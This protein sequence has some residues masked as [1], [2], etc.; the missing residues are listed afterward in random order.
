MGL[1]AILFISY[2]LLSSLFINDHSKGNRSTSIN[3]ATLQPGQIRLITELT[4]PVL[5]LHRTPEMIE[6]LKRPSTDLHHEID[7]NNPLR[8]STEQYLVI[9]AR[10]HITTK[11]DIS[12]YIVIKHL[13][14]SYKPVFCSGRTVQW[15][16]GFIDEAG[17]DLCFDYAGRV[18]NYDAY[19]W[20]KGIDDLT[21]PEHEI[22]DDRW[23]M[24][25]ID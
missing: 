14:K 15:H 4:V 20:L 2:I 25:S 10:A 3:L 22:S 12:N 1:I 9:D 23:L 5:V 17:R 18:Y 21:V 8:S 6:Q 13:P 24:I 16:G 7:I 19:K 11:S